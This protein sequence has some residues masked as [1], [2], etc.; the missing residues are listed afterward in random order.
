MSLYTVRSCAQ[1]T[2]KRTIA[3]CKHERT[4]V[5]VLVKCCDGIVELGEER[6]GESV[7]RFWSVE[8]DERDAVPR[9]RGEDVLVLL[10]GHDRA[11]EETA[12][13][14]GGERRGEGARGEKE[15]G[16]DQ[17]ALMNSHDAHAVEVM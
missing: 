16:H 15:R 6:G 5:L 17:G 10:R 7:E 14:S 12:G 4:D 3:P 8:R 13:A 1:R 2:C 9:A 11:E